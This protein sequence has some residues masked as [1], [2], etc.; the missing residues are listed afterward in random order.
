MNG[1]P[2][3]LRTVRN[4]PAPRNGRRFAGLAA[5][6]QGTVDMVE[7]RA[8]RRI[9]LNPGDLILIPDQP[10]RSGVA[11]QI[12]A[13]VLD[14]RGRPD[15]RCL[16]LADGE[17]PADGQG[18]AS[19]GVDFSLFHAAPF[20]GWYRA[21][22]GD[23]QRPDL[24]WTLLDTGLPTASTM[25][26]SSPY[27]DPADPGP[28]VLRAAKSCVVWLVH[29]VDPAALVGGGSVGSVRFQIQPGTTGGRQLPSPLAEIR[30]EF[31]IPRATARAYELAKGEF[32]QVIDIEGQQCSDFM[33]FRG[34]GLDQGVEQ[35]IDNTVTR[36]MVR[37]AYPGPG[38]F[39]KFYDSEMRPLLNV[40]Q[41]TVGRHDT[42]A[43]ACTARGYEERGF[44]GH[45]NCSDNIS[46][47]MDTYG[48][49]RRSA[50]P[51]INFF[52]NTWIDRRDNLI[53]SEESWSR[54][55]DYVLMRAM[56][57][58][59]CVSTA[60]PD[61]IDPI[62][63]WNP[64][65]VHV[66]IYRSESSIG[67]AVAFRPKEDAPMSMTR[68]SAFHDRT[69]ELTRSFQPARDLWLP[70]SY[71]ASGV[72]GEYWACREAVTVQDMSSLRK[73]DVVGPDAERLLQLALTR[74]V[75]RL[76]QWR[77]TYS[78]MCDQSGSVIDDGTLFRL[79]PDLFRWC[80][81]SE[82][83]ARHL[84][85]VAAEENLD[86]RI[87]DL[88]DSLP[89]LAIQGPLS[90]DVMTSLIFTQPSV[91]A[92]DDL[93]WFG[94]TVGRLHD[95]EGVPVMVSRSGYTGE[96]GYEVFCDKSGALDVW[97]AIAMTGSA[98]GITP[99]GGD[100][101]EL[102]RIEAGFVAA[103]AEF[104]AGIDALEA[105]LGF[106]V[107]FNKENF[108]GRDALDRNR[109]APRRQLRGLRLDCDDVPPSGS[110][111]YVGERPVGTVTSAVRSPELKTAI[112]MAH[113][114]V[115][116]AE[117]GTELEVGVMG[118]HMKRLAATVVGVP[119]VDP[120][121]TRPRS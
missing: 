85:A 115:E 89:N 63:G 55:G 8:A 1:Q 37:R 111:V 100:A 117:T 22:G 110:H 38:L 78:A 81:G 105:G 33:A 52:F 29:T 76:A 74:N 57:N 112:A 99:M 68:N 90:R 72:L 106:A 97:D 27:G 69:S 9:E 16:G 92:V 5:P 40:I 56:D 65:D 75:G 67:K 18:L 28:L 10:A 47:V 21:N 42:F 6:V 101:L 46:E 120:Q 34:D 93:K 54:A 2:T 44:P 107:D 25:S 83:S 84:A 51:A 108:I 118:G 77:G 48:V 20:L 116:V 87:S 96:L 12:R 53:R 95:R 70:T 30:D 11:P 79:A 80:C 26:P 121:R 36:S 45:V 119:F 91:P 35:M 50:W 102:L 15:P 114:A 61:D 113:L 109:S 64:T 14:D 59:V 98:F 32:V 17:G 103:G 24:V 3:V 86:V 88:G 7:P 66:R 13:L 4:S 41:D 58:L 19:Q 62:N 43:L 104:A 23:P 82:E 71:P 60:C 94:V 39:D 31:T 73:V 49:E